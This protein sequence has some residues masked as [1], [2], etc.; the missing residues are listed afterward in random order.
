MLDIRSNKW[1]CEKCVCTLH[2]LLDTFIYTR[3]N[4]S[5]TDSTAALTSLAQACL[6]EVAN[7]LNSFMALASGSPYTDWGSGEEDGVQE[8]GRNS[9]NTISIKR[10]QSSTWVWEKHKTIIMNCTERMVDKNWIKLSVI[11]AT[12]VADEEECRAIRVRISRTSWTTRGEGRTTSRMYRSLG[13]S[14]IFN[15]PWNT[16]SNNKN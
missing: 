7:T 8:V 9:D 11:D 14:F 13:S 3:H 10:G 5:L 16:N 15:R 12:C 2:M 4:S 6:P 1:K